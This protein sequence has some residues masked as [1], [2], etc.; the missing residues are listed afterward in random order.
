MVYN[1]RTM[2]GSYGAPDGAGESLRLTIPPNPR[3]A[4]WVRERVA[5][6]AAFHDAP[7]EDAREF[8]TAVG[9]ALANAIEHSSCAESIVI[10]CRPGPHDSIVATVVDCGSGFE[11]R[12][13][14]ARDLPPEFAERGRGLPIMRSCS[15]IFELHSTPGRGT[16]VTLGRFLRRRDPF[17]TRHVV[18]VAAEAYAQPRRKAEGQ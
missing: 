18:R 12:G 14:A 16:E 7:V 10:T 8:V 6:F 5:E 11:P 17:G 15:D 1:N 2:N 9:E 13:V 3:Y 4:R